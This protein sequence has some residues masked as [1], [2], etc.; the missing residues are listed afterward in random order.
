MTKDSKKKEMPFAYSAV[1]DMF[2][3]TVR[4]LRKAKSKVKTLETDLDRYSKAM[5]EF[6]GDVKQ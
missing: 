3:A 6:N 1:S 5:G 2:Y 4:K